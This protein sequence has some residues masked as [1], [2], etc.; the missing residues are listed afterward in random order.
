MF[1]AELELEKRTPWVP[2]LLI[3]ALAACIV[4]GIA[5]F[6]LES[7]KQLT[8]Q[9][10]A[11]V[12]AA[13]LKARGPTAVHFHGG[14]V[15]PSVD[16]KPRDPHYRLL[17]K[18]GMLKLANAKSGGTLVALTPLGE[19]ELPKV[20]DFKKW[21]NADGTDAYSVPLAER[22]LVEINKVTNAGPSLATVEYTW[23]W[24]PNKLGDIFDASG[25]TVKS[26]NTWERATLIQKYGVEFYH[27]N[28][29]KTTVTLVRTDKGWKVSTE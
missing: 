20:P 7:K 4:G 27:G 10:A 23:K 12:V 15:M 24:E 29:T 19:R 8:P 28:P 2:L 25:E 26:F 22:K 13:L 11:G 14:L 9:R 6:I 17:E 16:E 21:K 3:I 18:A 5:Y 1:E